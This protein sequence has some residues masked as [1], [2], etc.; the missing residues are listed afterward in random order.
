MGLYEAAPGRCMPALV[1]CSSFSIAIPQGTLSGQLPTGS[2]SALSDPRLLH[3]KA[4]RIGPRDE[5]SR[6]SVM[7]P[8]M[9]QYGEAAPPL[10]SHSRFLLFGA[11]SCFSNLDTCSRAYSHGG[12]RRDNPKSIYL[13]VSIRT[14]TRQ[15]TF[16]RPLIV[17]KTQ[18]LPACLLSFV[19]LL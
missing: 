15:T 13:V 18:N 19:S 8:W 5:D 4:D 16:P 6:A 12:A 14:G 3:D 2:A 10:S 11:E 9:H 17:W 1:G 7:D